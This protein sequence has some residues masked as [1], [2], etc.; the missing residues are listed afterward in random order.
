MGLMLPFAQNRKSLKTLKVEN[1]IQHVECW[2][3]FHAIAEIITVGF[4]KV[5]G[6]A[7]E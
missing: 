5:R 6:S 3:Q 2:T 7:P 4:N 1:G